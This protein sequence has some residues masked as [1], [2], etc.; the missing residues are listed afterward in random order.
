MFHP[1]S[2][3]PTAVIQGTRLEVDGIEVL[4]LKIPFVSKDP[5]Q[6]VKQIISVQEKAMPVLFYTEGGELIGDSHWAP[7]VD[8]QKVSKLVFTEIKLY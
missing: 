4:I 8:R 5:D 1:E 3:E 2:D 6:A 7:K